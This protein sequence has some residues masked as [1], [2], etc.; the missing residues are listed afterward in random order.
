MES[1]GNERTMYRV[2]VPG[3]AMSVI[4]SQQKPGQITPNQI[5]EAMLRVLTKME[6]RGRNPVEE[7]LQESLLR[8]NLVDAQDKFELV[9]AIMSLPEMDYAMGKLEGLATQEEGSEL[10][11]WEI[12]NL[13]IQEI[14]YGL[15]E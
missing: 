6:K 15:E 11:E 14:L 2:T 13:T 8:K 10:D 4:V 7:A 1:K 12:E 3:S 9:E 5:R